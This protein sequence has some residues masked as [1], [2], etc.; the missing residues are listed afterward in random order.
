[1]RWVSNLALALLCAC[2][3][4]SND[5]IAFLEAT[6]R[7]QQLHVQVPQGSTV[8]SLC[9]IGPADIYTNAKASGQNINKGV[10]DILAL[11]DAAVEAGV[12]LR[13]TIRS[14]GPQTPPKKTAPTSQGRSAWAS[15]A[16]SSA[17]AFAFARRQNDP[18]QRALLP[19]GCR[20]DAAAPAQ[21]FA[22]FVH[23]EIAFLPRYG[24]PDS[25]AYQALPDLGMAAPPGPV[26]YANG[27]AGHSYPGQAAYPDGNS[28]GGY[29]NSYDA[30]YGGDPYA[31]GGYGPYPSRG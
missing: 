21:Q 15:G 26:P 29:T 24:E 8:Q 31:G 2:G 18:P 22:D 9:A 13:P 30:G 27:H 3:N 6:P 19:S 1:M 11:V 28:A 20:G 16:S 17:F 4:L 7:S 14:T 23:V 5:D 10:D 25:P 12:T